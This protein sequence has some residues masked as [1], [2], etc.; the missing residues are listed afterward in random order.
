MSKD[1]ENITYTVG[2][3]EA[4]TVKELRKVDLYERAGIKTTVSDKD[5]IIKDMMDFQSLEQDELEE[6][7]SPE[8][9]EETTEETEEEAEIKEGEFSGPPVFHRSGK[10]SRRRRSS[11]TM[12]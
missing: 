11:M 3:L 2:Q 10:R 6:N 7:D 5:D 12:R 4:F 9:T 8:N 1:N